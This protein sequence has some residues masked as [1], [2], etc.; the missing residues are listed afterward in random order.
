MQQVR[1]L[2]QT[3][4]IAGARA[5][6]QGI[7]SRNP[8]YAPAYLELGKMLAQSGEL[9]PALEHL[10]QAVALA[11]E[12]D[13]AHV[14][15]G[16][17]HDMRGDDRAAEEGYRAALAINPGQAA[18]HY[19]L[20][21]LLKRCGRSA[22]ALRHLDLAVAHAPDFEPALREQALSLIGLG[23]FDEAKASLEDAVK[24]RPGSGG[25]QAYLGFAYQEQHCPAEALAC[26]GQAQRLGHADAE[27]HKNLGIVLQELGRLPESLAA[28]DRAIALQ[29][30]Y[31]LAR[32]HRALARLLRGD[33][34]EGWPDYELRLVSEDRPRRPST[35]PRWDGGGL[36]GK[37]ILVH[38]EQG[39]GDEIMFASCIPDLMARAGACV[40]ECA[41][42][43]EKLFR[44][45]FPAAAV[46]T[47]SSAA[48]GP[49]A[50]CEVPAGSL[51]LHF[52][53][54][55]ADFPAHSGYLRADPQR[56]DYW[57]ARLDALGPGVKV[58]LSWRGGTHRTRSPLR[59][60][61]LEHWLPILRADK[62]HFVSLQYG[63]VDDDL[64]EFSAAAGIEIAHWP[65]AIADYDETAA[66]MSALDFTISVCTAV[67]HLGGALGRP[68]WVMAPYSPEWRYGFAGVTMPWY[69][70]V[71]IFRQ[72]AFG[73]W[74]SV[75]DRVA[76]ALRTS[77]SPGR[78]A[79]VQ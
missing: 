12:S 1:H 54:S 66:L 47:A 38:G 25:L 16:N 52:R 13:E 67:I 21:L 55:L 58:G 17:V 33:F 2:Q 76:R 36:A 56:V 4:D 26:Y 11:P 37:T 53:R 29:P 42:A 24:R 59:S 23:R 6:C 7:L 32:F 28:Y 73:D 10:R 5:A 18:A 31:P 8:R 77:G 20:G 19:N 48:T 69:P 40:I 49:A 30:D 39:L 78:D 41:P 75:I 63:K 45:S 9:D 79:A 51:P 34:A 74:T 43:F 14:A 64:R 72:P 3:G 61:P 44:R 68:V 15:L 57:K 65:E 70:S 62:M 46:R 60:I 71:R 22:E 35:L 27:L 50:D